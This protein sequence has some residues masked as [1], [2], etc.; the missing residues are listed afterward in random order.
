MYK[1]V[2][3]LALVACAVAAPAPA[4]GYPVAYH[5]APVAYHAAP[6]AYHAAPVVHAAPAVYHAAPVIASEPL[7]T[8]HASLYKVDKSTK[9]VAH[10]PLVTYG[11][12][13]T[14]AAA[15]LTAV[16]YVH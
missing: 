12:A 5:A 10:Q 7:A 16:Q 8:S 2:T 9:Y 1:F 4:P 13:Y 14:Y 3:L 6:V 15:P 11:Q